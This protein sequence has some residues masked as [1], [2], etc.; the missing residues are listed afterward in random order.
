LQKKLSDVVESHSEADEDIKAFPKGS[1]S[2]ITQEQIRFMIHE[3]D[4]FKIKITKQYVD[5]SRHKINKMMRTQA[6]HDIL[7]RNTTEVFSKVDWE[8]VNSAETI[9]T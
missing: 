1:S 9:L 8:V 6:E 4:Q 3:F 2:A 7:I 5:L